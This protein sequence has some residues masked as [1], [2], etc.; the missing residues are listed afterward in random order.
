MSLLF[1]VAVVLQVLLACLHGYIGAQTLERLYPLNA[2]AEISITNIP[3]ADTS[4]RVMADA[5]TRYGVGLAQ[6]RLTIE[7]DGTHRQIL[8][9]TENSNSPGLTTDGQS[10]P[11]FGASVITEVRRFDIDADTT[12]GR[13]VAYGDIGSVQSLV[14]ELSQQGFSVE[15]AQNDLG[16]RL[17]L[18]AGDGILV[19]VQFAGFM[20]LLSAALL[21][22][23]RAT[24]TRSV[25]ALHGRRAI[26]VGGREFAWYVAYIASTVVAVF[27]IWMLV[28]AAL[29]GAGQ[30]FGAP[31]LLVMGTIAGAGILASLLSA[32]AL[33]IVMLVNV[34]LVDQFSGKRPLG[35][36]LIT[37]SIACSIVFVGVLVSWERT[38][39]AVERMEVGVE[40]AALWTDRSETHSLR[41]IGVDQEV[42]EAVLPQWK[43]FS[44]H[45]SSAGQILLSYPEEKCSSLRLE[46]P[47]LFVSNSYLEQVDVR[48]ARGER[49]PS[50]DLGR[51]GVGIIVPEGGNVEEEQ[52]R[53]GARS[54]V[55]FQHDL[56]AAQ[57][58]SEADLVNCDELGSD[59]DVQA[60]H[61]AS[62]QTLPVFSGRFVAA[63]EDT[64]M[65]DPVIVVLPDGGLA[66][67]ADFHLAAASQG[68]ELYTLPRSDL[69]QSIN[70]FGLQSLIF[71]INQPLDTAQGQTAE[72]SIRLAESTVILVAGIFAST[73]LT[74]VLVGVYCERRRRPLFVLHLHGATFQRRYSGYF[75]T[76]FGVASI[77]IIAMV[78]TVS[79]PFRPSLFAGILTILFLA[80]VSVPALKIN[81]QRFRADFIKRP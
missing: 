21:S 54:W 7:P 23:S 9:L 4:S 35:L 81:D 5:A 55:E 63:L 10:Y 24:K 75:V 33:W 15:F 80:L 67:S 12:P 41:L 1:K 20:M 13:W 71:S 3:M 37:G 25:R 48:D 72:A 59:V 16:T 30:T 39:V 66:P 40:S 79:D 45:L 14:T 78:G 6:V 27:V 74:L 58:C 36:I 76:F 49:I 28:A 22:A 26:Y 2:S 43:A 47:C 50:F 34:K 52:V 62:D 42:Y 29:W 11:D 17:G 44:N 56:S 64:V 31:G 8:L 60:I 65:K 46:A 57:E 19:V 69:Q 51:M 53:A 68:R 18:L 32:F 77:A 73:A 61:S 38:A 70:S